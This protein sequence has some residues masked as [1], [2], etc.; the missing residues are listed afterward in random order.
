MNQLSWIC[1]LLDH[2]IDNLSIESVEKE[3]IHPRKSYK[4]NSSCAD[5]ILTAANQW[6]ITTPSLLTSRDTSTNGIDAKLLTSN[7]FWLDIQL[8]WGNYDTNDI[9][10]YSRNKY[11]QYTTDTMSLYPSASGILIAIDLAYNY[12]SAYGNWFNNLKP[13]MQN[14]LA[15]IMKASPA[16]HVL[17]ERI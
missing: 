14:G 5:I 6:F 13:L 9:D 16:L 2:E 3:I 7:K 17:R 11:L 12:H 15:K 1:Q 8:R 10:Q 4:M